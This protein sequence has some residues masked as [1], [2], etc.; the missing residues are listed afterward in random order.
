MNHLRSLAVTALAGVALVAGAGCHLPPGAV[1]TVPHDLIPTSADEGLKVA[2][3]TQNQRRL[4]SLLASPDTRRVEREA[5][6][7][8]VQGFKSE[9]E[10]EIAPVMGSVVKTTIREGVHEVFGQKTQS[11]I[12]SFVGGTMTDSL[13]DVGPA[14][15]KVMREN[16]GPGIGGALESPELNRALGAMAHSVA[17]E[18]VSG[19]LE[20]IT[21]GRSKEPHDTSLLGRALSLMSSGGFM[22]LVITVV[23]ALVLLVLAVWIMKL[24]VQAQRLR[25]EVASRNQR[26]RWLTHARKVS[27]GKPWSAEL[28]AVIEAA[29][30]D[31]PADAKTTARHA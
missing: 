22:P 12:K 20:G 7:G 5:M 28:E 29:L 15:Q 17:K 25:D 24:L 23:V 11:E 9:V 10:P 31:A 14:V 18:A 6:A 4:A 26:E 13:S 16:V 8:L 2:E 21:E 3:N 27:K 19:A 30:E 1:K